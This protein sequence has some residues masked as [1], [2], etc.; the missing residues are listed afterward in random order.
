MH[1]TNHC[2]D[3]V[4]RSSKDESYIQNHILYKNEVTY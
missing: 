2:R 3:K 4:I 1:M